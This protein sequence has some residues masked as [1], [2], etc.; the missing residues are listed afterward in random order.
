[1]RILAV[2]ANQ[3]T[4]GQ[5][6][7]Q[8]TVRGDLILTP[9]VPYF[10]APGDEFESAVVVANQK[11]GS[12]ESAQVKIQVSADKLEA[13]GSLESSVAIP[14]GQE[15]TQF[16]S[17]RAK[18]ILGDSDIKFKAELTGTVVE[19]TLSLSIRPPQIFQTTFF[20]ERIG[21]ESILKSTRDVYPEF[22]QASATLS[23]L[24]FSFIT[25]AE[26]YLTNYEY[27]CSEQLLSRALGFTALD[28]LGLTPQKLKNFE[29]S[30]V[31]RR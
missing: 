29:T 18:D 8:V 3:K 26:I 28:Q 12:G 31:A 14:E 21:K 7:S 5:F 6:N 30:S 23:E 10:V 2:S 27:S 17:L 4:F 16:F 20:A 22:A 11:R 1:M 15:K 13:V 25:A 9:S 24:P 19:R